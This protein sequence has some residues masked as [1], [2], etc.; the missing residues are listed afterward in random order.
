MYAIRSYY[1]TDLVLLDTDV[2]RVFDMDTI[3]TFNNVTIGDEI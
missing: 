2:I 1:V 3:I